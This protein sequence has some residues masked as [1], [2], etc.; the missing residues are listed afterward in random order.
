MIDCKSC[1]QTVDEGLKFCGNCGTAVGEGPATPAQSAVARGLI[2]QSLLGQY[3]IESKLGEGGMGTVYLADQPSMDRKAVIKV[4]HPHLTS[5]EKWVARFNREAKIASKLTHPNSI[6]LYN[7]GETEEGYVYIAMEF[8][9]GPPLADLIEE[10]GAMPPERVLRIIGQCAGAMQEAWQLGIVHR[11]LKPDNVLVSERGGKDWAKVLDFGIAKMKGA[12]VDE[13]NLTATGM[14]FG[15][16]A[17]MSPEQFSGEELDGRSDLYSL[18]IMAYEMLCG[19]RPFDAGTPIGYFKL[20]LEELPPPMASVSPSAGVSRA[21]EEVIRKSLE[22][23]PDRRQATAQAFADELGAAVKSSAAPKVAPAPAD[24]AP[25]LASSPRLDDPAEGAGLSFLERMESGRLAPE[26]AAPML[27]DGHAGPHAEAVGKIIDEPRADTS[28]PSAP[29]AFDGAGSVPDLEPER[30]D[31]AESL[32]L[33]FEPRETGASPNVQIPEGR[34]PATRSGTRPVARADSGPLAVPPRPASSRPP[35]GT[36]ANIRVGTAGSALRRPGV[37]TPDLSGEMLRSGMRSFPKAPKRKGGG[38]LMMG[39]LVCAAAAIGYVA[40]RDQFVG[41]SDDGVSAREG[42]SEPAEASPGAAGDRG[43]RAAAEAG[44]ATSAG[45]VVDSRPAAAPV[46]DPAEKSPTEG[47]IRV[48][49]GVYNLG[50][51][52]KGANALHA[53][54]LEP[55]WLDQDEVSNEQWSRCVAEGACKKAPFARDSRFNKARQPVAGVGYRAA[56]RYCAWA[57]HRL[58]TADEWEA[59]ARGVER[60]T[61]PWGEE[62]AGTPR[63]NITGSEDG[64]AWTAPVG[65]FV[66]GNTMP[67]IRDLAGNVAEWVWVSK[68]KGEIRGGSFLSIESSVASYGITATKLPKRAAFTVGFRCAIADR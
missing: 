2:G 42:D 53:V 10:V 62:F 61:Y 64:H 6:T 34:A 26:E 33:A 31:S 13:M 54:T 23:S 47:M 3:E 24:P 58:P 39:I 15:T 20:H 4:L 12:A 56:Q 41:S 67:G 43:R 9:E 63:A 36:S 68:K 5:D 7:Y 38:L 27:E 48:D 21:V 65:S 57:G 19:K 1:G 51:D 50:G 17:Y 45:V 46:A 8:V 11:D 55:F 44:A 16:P 66:R 29:R 60:R 14:V 30:S 32:E 22:K 52:P 35:G 59:A 25:E 40:F 18:G 49:A 37:T 28:R